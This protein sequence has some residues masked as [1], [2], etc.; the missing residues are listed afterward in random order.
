MNILITHD[1]LDVNDV[2][3]DGWADAIHYFTHKKLVHVLATL[4]MVQNDED[5]GETYAKAINDTIEEL[6][7][8]RADD[9]DEESPAP[10][11]TESERDQVKQFLKDSVESM[12]PYMPDGGSLELI[13]YVM[14]LDQT[15]F[16]LVVKYHKDDEHTCKAFA[17]PSVRG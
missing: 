16:Y 13:T 3:H 5:S 8:T 4:L 7:G 12:R 1:G 11:L 14:S 6:I 9:Q 15:K 10:E 2:T 17:S